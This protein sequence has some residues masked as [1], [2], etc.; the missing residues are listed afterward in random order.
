MTT[1][2]EIIVNGILDVMLH[3]DGAFENGRSA[4]NWK[5]YAERVI[6]ISADATGLYA[7][8]HA[9]YEIEKVLKDN[10]IEKE[11]KK[12]VAYNLLTNLCVTIL[13]L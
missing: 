3:I 6:K 4:D 13:N 12:N 7:M 1:K 9:F 10:R 8:K 5:N 11:K 2:N